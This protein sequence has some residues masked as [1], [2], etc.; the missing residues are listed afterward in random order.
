MFF[1]VR[2][3]CEELERIA[4][5][6]DAGELRPVVAR[7]F[8]LADGRAAYA[9]GALPRPPGRTALVVR[10]DWRLPDRRRGPVSRQ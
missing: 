3:D 7:T 8:P 5:M 1:V 2:P 6:V 9:S 10:P 4:A